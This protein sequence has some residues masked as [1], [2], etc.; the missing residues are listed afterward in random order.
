MARGRRPQGPKLVEG[1]DGSAA[2]KQRL[3]VVLET[4][5]GARSV[6]S[7]CV[8][9]GIS[10]ARFH[11]LRA[12]MLQAA[13]AGA[14]PRPAGRPRQEPAPAQ[15]QIAALEAEIRDLRIDLKA[16]QVREEIAV[17]MPHLLQPPKQQPQRYDAEVDDV[18]DNAALKKMPLVSEPGPKRRGD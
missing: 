9:L 15:A 2:A 12:A 3:Q 4:V 10:E 11:E 17:A 13:L 1:L 8:T 18:A 6:A 5:A 14:E 7:A 16:A